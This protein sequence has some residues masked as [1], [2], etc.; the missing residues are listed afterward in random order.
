MAK[1]FELHNKKIS[2]NHSHMFFISQSFNLIELPVP[3]IAGSFSFNPLQN[4]LYGI[5][6]ETF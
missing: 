1:A 2:L 4:I 6:H 3:P 5:Y